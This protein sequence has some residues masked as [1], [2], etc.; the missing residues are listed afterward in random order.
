MLPES[1]V[2]TLLVTEA[3]EELGAPYFIGG[4][5]ATALHGVARTTMDVDLVV[6]LRPEHVEPFVDILGEAFYADEIMMRDAILHRGS[7]NLLHLATMFKVDIFIFKGRPFDQAQFERRVRQVLVEQPLRTA[8]VASPE[9]NV[10]AKLEWYRLGGEV[11]ERQWRDVV[12]VIKVQRECL[13]HS[14]LMR[15]AELLGVG[16]LLA[17]A[18]AEAGL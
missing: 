6:D 1:I 16:D 10:L 7:F 12:S 15:W 14:Y 5:L 8:F 2:V 4:S 17:S 13:D 3:L 18:L 11:S 9:D